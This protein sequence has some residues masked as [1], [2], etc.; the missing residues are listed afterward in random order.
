MNKRVLFV[1]D[2]PNVLD[3][4]RRNL[5]KDFEIETCEDPR[6]ALDM[7]DAA[8]PFAVIVSDMRMPEMD[9][10]EFLAL[11]RKASPDS[12]RVMLTGNSDQDTAMAAVNRG[13]VFQFL[14]KPADTDNLREVLRAG[15]RQFQLVTA[16][17]E[18]L[19]NTLNGSIQVLAEV[20][21]ITNPSAFGRTDRIRAKTQQVARLL[22]DVSHWELETAVSISQLGCVGLPSELLA[23]AAQGTELTRSEKEEYQAHPQLAADLVA[24]IPRMEGVADIVLYQNK[25]FD[26]SGYPR[27]SRREGD[28]PLGARI[29]RVV[30]AFDELKGQG[31]SDAATLESLTDRAKLFDPQ[32]LDALGKTLVDSDSTET[33]RVPVAELTDGMIV[34]EDVRSDKGVLLVCQGQVVTATVRRH[35]TKFASSG[36]LS[37]QVLVTRAD[38]DSTSAA[39]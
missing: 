9:G 7:L 39:A 15:L 2:E 33:R 17:K 3:A 36:A 12:V 4:V 25:N 31:W 8:E 27:D 35:L 11:A 34:Q 29:L 23:K 38:S 32:V 26:G 10:A 28:V 21:S 19:G 5:R 6:R 24:R 14:T 18:L 22:P 13:A 20:L 37:G 30:L 1:D 16:E